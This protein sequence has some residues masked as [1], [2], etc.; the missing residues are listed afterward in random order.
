VIW[1][2]I[3]KELEKWGGGRD[4]KREGGRGRERGRKERE[5]KEIKKASKKDIKEMSE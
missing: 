5:S 2:R 4:V 1:N 3:N